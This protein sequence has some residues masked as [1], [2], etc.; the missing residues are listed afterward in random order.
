MATAPFL[1]VLPSW[2]EAPDLAVTAA[3]L[4]RM[5]QRAQGKA[6]ADSTWGARELLRLREAFWHCLVSCPRGGRRPRAVA[7]RARGRDP[8]E[9]MRPVSVAELLVRRNLVLAAAVGRLDFRVDAGGVARRHPECSVDFVHHG[10]DSALADA[11]NTWRVFLGCKA[12]IAK[13]FFSVDVRSA[14]AAA[15][16]AAQWDIKAVARFKLLGVEYDARA[17]ACVQ[18]DPARVAVN[19]GVHDIDNIHAMHGLHGSRANGGTCMA[20]GRP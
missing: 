9:G 4:R 14:A 15:R 1:S 8:S 16:L 20:P 6:S 18:V 13:C 12:D 10:L 7:C 5:V 19:Y 11:R 3:G 2:I 17:G